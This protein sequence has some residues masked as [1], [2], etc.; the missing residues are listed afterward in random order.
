[1]KGRWE[2]EGRGAGRR[3]LHFEGSRG[4]F[5][6]VGCYRFRASPTPQPSHLSGTSLT[7][8]SHAAPRCR[9]TVRLAAARAPHKAMQDPCCPAGAAVLPPLPPGTAGGRAGAAPR[10]A[11]STQPGPPHPLRSRLPAEG[12][13]KNPSVLKK[14]PFQHLKYSF[15]TNKMFVF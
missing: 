3:Q 1:M 5:P 15:L 2:E 10:S 12:Y 6:L 7:G 13:G 11:L 14:A 8:R 9:R 4:G